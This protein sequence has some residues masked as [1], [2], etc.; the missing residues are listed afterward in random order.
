[1][2]KVT[3]RAIL[4]EEMKAKVAAKKAEAFMKIDSKKQEKKKKTVE[5]AAKKSNY[6]VVAHLPKLCRPTQT[7]RH[8]AE[9]ADGAKVRVDIKPEAEQIDQRRPRVAAVE[10]AHRDEAWWEGAV[11]VVRAYRKLTA[12]RVTDTTGHKTTAGQ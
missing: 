10:Q 9:S 8:L 6:E 12:R 1:M 4:L 5:A 11:V 3:Q 7:S 2:I